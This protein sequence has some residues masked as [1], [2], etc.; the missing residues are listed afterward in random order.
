MII[1]CT[2]LSFTSLVLD[3]DFLRW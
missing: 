2:V 3:G 1:E